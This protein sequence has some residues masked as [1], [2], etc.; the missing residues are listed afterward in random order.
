MASSRQKTKRRARK[1]RPLD[2][3]ILV[4]K[5]TGMSSHSVL[6]QVKTLFNAQKAGHTG[7]LDPAASGLLPICLGDATK[8]AQFLIDSDKTYLA[9]CQLGIKTTT[10]DAEGDIISQRPTA[11]ISR[12][13][14][15]KVS[16]QFM[17]EI[18][19]IPPMYSSVKQ[20]GVR[21]YEL[22]RRGEEVER[23]QRQ[24]S[25]YELEI[26]QWYNDSHFQI[27]I[28]C[29]KGTYI[30][31]IAEDM[32][33]VLGCG[34]SLTGLRRLQVGEFNHFYSLEL[35]KQLSEENDEQLLALLIDIPTA[36]SHFPALQLSITATRRLCYG[37]ETW[38]TEW[39]KENLTSGFVRLFDAFENRFLGIGE[40]IDGQIYPHRLVSFAT[41][42]YK[43]KEAIY[44]AEQ[45][46]QNASDTL[47]E[48]L[49]NT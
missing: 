31:T 1:A 20:Q 47:A 4:D 19:Q 49:T 26:A 25:V 46:A 34:A 48:K 6:Q 16:Q 15:E 33:E 3:F 12:A 37:Q 11:H 30:R 38:N 21:L 17:G 18:Q 36:L 41:E 43:E 24:V 32:G 22:A 27:K 14:I 23:Q 5:P 44:L 9:D 45:A 39:D 35:L 42:Y 28:H 8:F 40:I 29:S 2:G 10:G 13:E 7:T